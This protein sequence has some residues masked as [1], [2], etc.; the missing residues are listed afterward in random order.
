MKLHLPK[1]L[2][3]A[4]LAV[5]ALATTTYSAWADGTPTSAPAE[6]TYLV[7]T[8]S[9]NYTTDGGSKDKT[10][11][12]FGS[13]DMENN[14]VL[15]LTF[16]HVGTNLFKD[17]EYIETG[18]V[19]I[20]NANVDEDK[21]TLNDVAQRHPQIDTPN[22]I[23]N[24]PDKFNIYW[25]SGGDVYVMT[26]AATVK[27][28]NGNIVSQKYSKS[29]EENLPATD[30]LVNCRNQVLLG[31]DPGGVKYTDPTDPTKTKDASSVYHV[32]LR[33]E[34]Q[35]DGTGTLWLD[36]SYFDHTNPY[37]G[38]PTEAFG[39]T[40]DIQFAIIESQELDMSGL[41]STLS[42]SIRDQKP[43]T[44]THELVMRG[45]S[46][47]QAWHISGTADLAKLTSGDYGHDMASGEKVIFV[48][49]EGMIYATETDAYSHNTLAE[50]D[51]L[52]G[53]VTRSVGFG[54]AAGKTLTVERTALNQNILSG[55]VM[56]GTEKC[57]L[58]IAGPGTVKFNMQDGGTIHQLAIEDSSILELNSQGDVSLNL[59][60]KTTGKA[61]IKH[62]GNSGTLTITG[63][64]ADTDTVTLATLANETTGGLLKI[65]HYGSI[66][67][68][69]ISSKGGVELYSDTTA[70][71]KF[72][73]NGA[74]TIAGFGKLTTKDLE[75]T[76]TGGNL[77]IGNTGSKDKQH[78]V[79]TTGGVVTIS[80]TATVYGT[81]DARKS[82]SVTATEI[83][84]Q[85]T[86]TGAGEVLAQSVQAGSI[87]TAG[88][89]ITAQPAAAAA[90]ST[91][92]TPVLSGNVVINENGIVANKVAAGTEIAL[93]STSTGSVT[94]GT[95][96]DENGGVTIDVGG[97][98]MTNV[99]AATTT[100]I[101][102]NSLTATNL[103]ADSIALADNY[104]LTAT[105]TLTVADTLTAGD[106]KVKLSAD[107]TAGAGVELKNARIQGNTT[108]GYDVSADSITAQNITIGDNSKLS[109]ATVKAS[110]D[111][112]AGAAT[113]QNVSIAQGTFK[114]TGDVELN[115]VTFV[116][117][118]SDSADTPAT[119]GGTNGT[120]IEVTAS[121]DGQDI[122]A[123]KSV[124]V[125]GTMKADG[126]LDI[127]RL[128]L[129]A[130]EQMIFG[131]DASNKAT[132]T[133]M[134]G[135]ITSTSGL[136]SNDYELKLEQN[137]VYA[138]VTV[139]AD[140]TVSVTGY[141]DEERLEKENTSGSA[142]R[143]AAYQAIVPVMEAD[144][145]VGALNGTPMQAIYNFICR[146]QNSVAERTA[147]LSALSGASTTALA[148][149]QRRGVRDVQSNL[150]NRVIQMGGGTNAGLTTDWKYAGIQAWAQA[151]G[152]FSTTDGQGDEYGYDFNTTGATVGAN[153]DLTANTVIG[154]SFS[155]SYGEIEVDGDD[156][157]S[158]NNDTYYLNLFMRH[159]SNRWVQM[160]ILTAGL[161]QMD[162]ERSVMGYQGTGETEGRTFSAYYEVGYTF[163]LDYDFNHILQ[164]L[165]SVSLTSATV[166]GYKEE[167]SIGNAGLDYDGGNYFYGQVGIGVRYQGVLYESAHERC[168]VLEARALITQDFGDATNEAEVGLLAGGNRYTVEGVDS[169]GTGFEIGVGLSIPVEQH[170]TVFA[171]ADF[172]YAPDY[173][174]VRANLGLRYDF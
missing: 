174:G 75:I 164:P 14:W 42:E 158:G 157:A 134:S 24:N 3:T 103:A 9:K 2:R 54:A 32:T 58:R 60:S 11:Y 128:V 165:V 25:T 88:I 117:N 171:D 86:A 135:N 140:G 137:G 154:M 122:E 149:S 110:G 160:L 17:S 96:G 121:K 139:N 145:G 41:F 45:T 7:Q 153:L 39:Y 131:D 113:L 68:D 94:A 148:D 147:V 108:G 73:A 65:S 38:E 129:N 47:E 109:G 72:A 62:S 87:N 130:N 52:G 15:N 141:Q 78:S 143:A 100:T 6:Y 89:T 144:A 31:R 170:T 23:K 21:I 56:A 90:A 132:Y 93:T 138:D 112:T 97:K 63:N 151:D 16:D 84:V 53:G 26:N 50:I 77:T 71:T 51:Y 1:G 46:G 43:S 118:A 125:T 13:V 10:S 44:Y 91:E 57:G 124:Q 101:S 152:G 69:E 172:T 61:H 83:T 120:A 95:L 99:V 166:D 105:G 80:G 4:L 115:N 104:S 30:R 34:A 36:N 146:P 5:V 49:D 173:M 55:V 76:G 8:F 116:G 155:A 74:V 114:N 107:T 167:G 82:T 111:I 18:A 59:N 150:R 37:T 70:S 142:N 67:A 161:N 66:V 123:I 136:G 40:R 35:G 98:E 29:Y 48:G 163:A 92:T 133:F 159:Q 102:K 126:S 27:D 162:M 81:L 169:T 79:T 64:A 156:H 106:N 127:S 33:W 85:K 119:F 168:A 12:D 22:E 28:V 20:G 19:L